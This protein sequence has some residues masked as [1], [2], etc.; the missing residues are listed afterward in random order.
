MLYDFHVYQNEQKANS[1]HATYLVYGRKAVESQ[2]GP[3]GD[4]EMS[5]SMPGQNDDDEPEVPTFTMGLVREE[6]LTGMALLC[7]RRNEV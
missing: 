1:V 6:N 5:S 7:L 4:V 2:K 3:D